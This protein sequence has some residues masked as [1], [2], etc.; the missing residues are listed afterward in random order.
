[1]FG[2]TFESPD[3]GA[4]EFKREADRDISGFLLSSG[5]VRNVLFQRQ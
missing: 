5:R 2:E 4:F 1:M 3:W